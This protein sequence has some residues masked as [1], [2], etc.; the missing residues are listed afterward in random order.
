M[1]VRGEPAEVVV[2]PGRCDESDVGDG[3]TDDASVAK[4]DRSPAAVVDAPAVVAAAVAGADPSAPPVAIG[5]RAAAGATGVTDAEVAHGG[6]K[7]AV[8]CGSPAADGWAVG[9][10]SVDAAGGHGESPGAV[11]PAESAPSGEVVPAGEEGARGD[12]E[13]SGGDGESGGA[14]PADEGN[15]SEED[16]PSGEG[17]PP[18]KDGVLGEAEPV[19]EAEPA[20]EGVVPG[21]AAP[22]CESLLGEAVDDELPDDAS[23]SPR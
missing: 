14:E 4:E 21:E 19:G 12:V 10:W 2:E 3:R 23:R 7:G 8:A 20:G 15:P 11:R 5:P 6:V 1:G 9:W 17:A 16:A 22:T 13:P 18:G